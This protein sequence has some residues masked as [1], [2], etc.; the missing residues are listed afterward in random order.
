VAQKPAPPQQLPAANQGNALVVRSDVPADL[1]YR[2]YLKYLRKD[3]VWSCAYC[4]MSE[5]EA[6]AIRFTIDHYEPRWARPDLLNAYDNLMYSCDE[7]NTRK[8]DLVPPE[9]A[10]QKGVRFFR[11]DMDARSDHFELEGVQVKSKTD[12]GEFSIDAIDLNRRSLRTL[13][14]IRQRL[15]RCD[16]MVAEGV[17]ALRRFH[18]DRLSESIKQR[19]ATTIRRAIKEATET[20]DD[21]DELLSNYARSP[22]LGP[23]DDAD[24]DAKEARQRKAQMADWKAL[25]PAYATRLK[26]D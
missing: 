11:P 25:F 8:G 13:R 9:T 3:F 12:I 18:I 19:A 20:A 10:R 1:P 7:C 21:I 26:K 6:M 24:A 14:D 23:D 17:L 4:T 5:A 2:E 15:T 16:E 22:L